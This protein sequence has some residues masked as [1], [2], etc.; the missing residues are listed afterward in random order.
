V[1]F[2]VC[3]EIF[4]DWPLAKQFEVAAEIGFDAIEVAPFTINRSVRNISQKT[5]QLIR[6]LA[7]QTGVEVAGVH[8]LLAQTEGYH[9]T[10]PDRQVRERTIEYMQELV[11]FGVEIGGSMEVVGSPQQRDV[12]D[13]VSYQQ[14]WEWFKEAMIAC[15]EVPGAEDFTICIEPLAPETNNNFIIHAEE[16]R[17]MVREIDRPNV[18]VILDTYSGTHVEDDFPTQI[19]QTGELLGHFHCNDYNQR[20][21]GW[22][23]TDFVPIMRALLD[24]GY[25]GYCSI[26]VFDFEPDPY[27]HTARGLATLKQALSA[28]GKL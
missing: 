15:A 27:E 7:K 9:L 14:A 4:Q 10:D 16:A 24:I 17:R 1:K 18:K 13:S 5:R 21:P 19:R 12:K 22:G 2:C 23:D 3:N 8:W 11:K 28:A 6:K 25:Q 20:A 26:E